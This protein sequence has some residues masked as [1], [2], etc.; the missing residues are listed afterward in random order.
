MNEQNGNLVHKLFIHAFILY[1]IQDK[2]MS[3]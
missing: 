1:Q 3:K 2:R